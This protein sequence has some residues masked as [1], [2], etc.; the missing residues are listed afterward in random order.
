MDPN[1]A[2]A[3]GRPPETKEADHRQELNRALQREGIEVWFR[4]Q[5]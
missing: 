5:A 4:L 3:S 1:L 2:T